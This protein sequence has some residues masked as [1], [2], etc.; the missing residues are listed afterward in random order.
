MLWY[1]A[2]S[3]SWYPAT[4]NEG[5]VLLPAAANE[6]GVSSPSGRQDCRNKNADQRLLRGMNSGLLLPVGEMKIANRGRRPRVA[7][8]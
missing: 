4:A 5:G 1:P 3:N 2:A 8:I 6:G 7:G